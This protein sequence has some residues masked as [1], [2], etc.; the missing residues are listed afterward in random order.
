MKNYVQNHYNDKMSYDCLRE[1]V[2]TIW[3]SIEQ[4][5]LNDLIDSLR[6]K[7]LTVIIANEKHTKYWFR[8]ISHSIAQSV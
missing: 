5:Q 7:C 8:N 1:I 2:K 4:Y 3:N 6:N